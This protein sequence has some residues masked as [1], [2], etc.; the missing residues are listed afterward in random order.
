[1]YG[2]VVNTTGAVH[3]FDNSY[4]GVIFDLGEKDVAKA[5]FVIDNIN[6][7]TFMLERFT[8][9]SLPNDHTYGTASGKPTP[10]SMVADNDE[11]TGRLIDAL[12]HSNYWA[13]SIVFVVEDDPSDGGDHVE[14][15]RSP[16]V[17]MSP[18]VKHGYVSS[19][20]YDDPALWATLNLLLGVK[21]MNG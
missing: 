12:S 13:S 3:L 2:E 6:D 4:P 16:C 8:Y 15:H 17:V 10:Q 19:V 5:Q 20:H 1:N 7:P 14:G 21:P 9:M 18:W 11:A